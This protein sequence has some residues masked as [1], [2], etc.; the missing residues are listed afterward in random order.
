MRSFVTDH[1]TVA[2][3]S[4]FLYAITLDD[5]NFETAIDTTNKTV[6]VTKMT[7]MGYIS[8]NATLTRT[9]STQD[10]MSANYGK[11]KSYKH[12][13]NTEFATS[14]IS[15]NA[16]NVANFMTGAETEDGENGEVYTYFGEDDQ[17]PE[18][19][20]VFVADDAKTG[21]KFT[22]VMPKASWI[23]DYLLDFNNDNPIALDFKFGCNNVTLPNGKTGSFWTINGGEAE[24]EEQEQTPATPAQNPETPGTSG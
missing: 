23:G 6:D 19:A 17:S 2:I 13:Y 18:I 21:V 7:E 10:I 20:L 12:T 16:K 15:Y 9:A 11:V 1:D 8:G 3:G 24:E 22:I 4:G 5:A 14:I